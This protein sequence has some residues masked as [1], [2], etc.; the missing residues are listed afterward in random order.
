MKRGSY[1]SLTFEEMQEYHREQGTEIDT[2]AFWIEQEAREEAYERG[3]GPE[4]D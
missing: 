1:N 2:D 4:W 3:Y